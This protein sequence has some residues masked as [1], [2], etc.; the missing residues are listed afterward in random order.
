MEIRRRLGDSA[1]TTLTGPTAIAVASFSPACGGSCI[2]QPATTQRLDT[3]SDR[4]MTRL[5]Y[6]NFG[7]HESLVVNH[8]VATGAFNLG[9]VGVRWYELRNPAGAVGP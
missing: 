2:A 5:A 3:L 7:D 1:N 9:P 4:L 8:S 6:R